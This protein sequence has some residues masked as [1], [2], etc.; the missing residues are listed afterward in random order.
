V[1]RAALVAELARIRTR[2]YA[3]DD[4]ELEAGL[5]CVGAPVRNYSGAVVASMSIAGPAFRLSR[6]RIPV[7]AEAVVEAADAL[8]ADLGYEAAQKKPRA[9]RAG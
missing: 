8:S 1:T 7:L 3:I 5:R 2:G 9:R 4:E 6:S